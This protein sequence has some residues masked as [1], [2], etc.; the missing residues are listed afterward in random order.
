LHSTI[1]LVS[2]VEADMDFSYVIQNY[3]VKKLSQRI[4][5]YR[6][7][8]NSKSTRPTDASS[9]AAKKFKL[10]PRTVVDEANR[11]SEE[12]Y[13]QHIEQL[14]KEWEGKQSEKHIKT[15]LRE[16]RKN[17]LHWQSSLPQGKFAP[18]LE[19]F[20]CF[21]EGSFVSINII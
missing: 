10:A 11:T 21:E 20:P 9:P 16:T 19:K 4:R 17:R 1:V 6:W 13:R 3:F 5:T 18:I 15:L 8:E 14:L 12:D 7:R 2:K